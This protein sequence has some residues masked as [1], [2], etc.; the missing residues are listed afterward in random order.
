[1]AQLLWHGVCL[2][3]SQVNGIFTKDSLVSV[4]PSFKCYEFKSST[5]AALCM[6]FQCVI[7]QYRNRGRLHF[8]HSISCNCCPPREIIVTRQRRNNLS[9]HV[10]PAYY[11]CIVSTVQPSHRCCISIFHFIHISGCYIYSEPSV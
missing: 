9:M 5:E 2:C 10:D 1:M 3:C 8:S 7:T 6:Q 11:V 4:V